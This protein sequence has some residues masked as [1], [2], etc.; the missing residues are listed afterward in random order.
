MELSLRIR[1]NRYEFETE[2][3]ITAKAANFKFR[4]VPIQ[5]V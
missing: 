1:S 5:T 3:I 4:E 2:Q